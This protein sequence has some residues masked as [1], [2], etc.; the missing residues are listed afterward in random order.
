M[1]LFTIG[2]ATAQGIKR[3]VNQDSLHAHV[4]DDETALALIAD[5]L[6]SYADSAEASA[7]TCK[8]VT[9][10]LVQAGIAALDRRALV[11]AVQA[12]NLALWEQA[13]ER[14]MHLKTTLTTM[15][16]RS[17]E[18]LIAHVGDCRVYHA[19]DGIVRQVTHDH[20]VVKGDPFSRIIG[21]FTKNGGGIPRH[22]LNRVIGENPIVRVDVEVVPVAAADR[23]VICSDGIWDAIAPDDFV[24]LLSTVPDDNEAAARFVQIARDNGTTDDASTI[25]ITTPAQN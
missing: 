10:S 9:A 22:L 6:G 2:S 7:L 15:V 4:F 1:A 8:L 11:A 13:D 5:G 19:H 17:P 3:N 14:G 20:S 21:R 24:K 18:I 16:L 23:F 12:A 25:V